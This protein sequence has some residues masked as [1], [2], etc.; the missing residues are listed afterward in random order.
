[1]TGSF[2]RMVKVI[3]SFTKQILRGEKKENH[4]LMIS[5]W[6]CFALVILQLLQQHYRNLKVIDLKT[7][8]AI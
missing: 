7:D 8:A 5:C 3:L 6:V 4:G 1:M 2:R